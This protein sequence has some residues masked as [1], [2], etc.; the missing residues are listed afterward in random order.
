MITKHGI[1]L[2]VE[3]ISKRELNYSINKKS[4]EV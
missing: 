4:R 3:Y 1:E 2:P